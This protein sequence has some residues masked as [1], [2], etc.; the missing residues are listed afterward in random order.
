[1]NGYDVPDYIHWYPAIRQAEMRDEWLKTHAA[2]EWQF[3]GQITAAER[4]VVTPQ[5]D[6]NYGY[7]WFNISNQP[8]V[9]TMPPYDKFSSL[10]V[11]DMHHFMEVIV[12]PDKPVVIRLPHQRSP[13][14]DAY[15]IV[16]HTY[17]GL[18]FTRQVI[19][20]NADEVMDLAAQITITGGGGDAPFIIPSF[21]SEVAEEGNAIIKNYGEH[22]VPDGSK[23]F[24]SPY[25]GVG[26]LDR[27]GG[28]FVGQLGTQAR[29]VNYA[30]YVQDQEGKPLSGSGSYEITVPASGLLRS[31]KGYWSITIYN[32]AD[33][34]LIPNEKSV[35]SINSYE[36]E[37]NADGTT[38]LRVRPDGEEQNGIPTAGLDFYGVF[39]VYGPVPGLVFPEVR[40]IG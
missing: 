39:R 24:G 3:T 38:T 16:L 21:S 13:I 22:H 4:T 14:D 31:D 32:L 40:R 26:D 37:P 11:F 28:V 34:Y 1:M 18:A 33:R 5:A 23:I 7:S 36:A 15:E 35:Y 27:A 25:E 20:G 2:G 6:T 30:Q 17:Q 10:S 19:A 29:Y 9:I 12:S 8:V